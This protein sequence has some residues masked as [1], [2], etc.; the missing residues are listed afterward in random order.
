MF[1]R[2]Q[3]EFLC[4]E[5]LQADG[6]VK[7]ALL[8]K[9]EPPASEEH[10]RKWGQVRSRGEVR[11][12]IT[13]GILLTA[14]CGI[15]GFILVGVWYEHKHIDGLWDYVLGNGIGWLIAGL[16]AGSSEW[17]A[18]QKRYE[19]ELTQFSLSNYETPEQT[20]KKM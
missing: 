7:I 13:K 18:N 3:F 17:R 5:R 20:L 9:K 2:R 16:F 11:F 19:R 14:I 12:V 10:F 1:F 4:K 6:P 8:V 15:L